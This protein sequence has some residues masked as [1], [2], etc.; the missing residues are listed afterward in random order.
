[1]DDL[2]KI[3]VIAGIL[4]AILLAGILLAPTSEETTPATAVEPAVVE[5]PVIVLQE[6]TLE[7]LDPVYSEKAVFQD[8]VIRISFDASYVDEGLQSRLPF[9]IHNVS[10]DV[11][12]ILWDRCSMQLPAGNTVKVVNEESAASPV[13]LGGTISI[14]PSGDLFDA[15]VPVSELLWDDE[16]GWSVT[17]GVLDAGPFTLVLAIE[18]GELR[19]C[20][21]DPAICT[22]E[23]DS[24][25][26]RARVT[27]ESEDCT[28]RCITY[29]T[30]RFVIR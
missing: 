17:T 27:E 11:I 15:I 8:G 5:Q 10:G 16:S 9:W 3:A 22:D 19:P 25:G 7:M 28:E 14:A 20:V 18:Y 29:Y 30:F 1:M 12:N 21:T 4:G 13:A 6:D 24:M 23:K 26:K 2:G